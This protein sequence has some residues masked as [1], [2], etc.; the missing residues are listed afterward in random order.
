VCYILKSAYRE[1]EERIGRLEGQ[2]GEKTAM[3][4]GAI[5]KAPGRFSVDD[6]RRECPGVSVDMIRRVLKDL[7]AEGRVECLGRGPR[8]VWQKIDDAAN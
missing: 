4:M 6:L 8:A 5:K 1:F 3:I 7:Q 2:R